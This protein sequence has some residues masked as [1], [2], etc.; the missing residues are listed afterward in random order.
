HQ[1]ARSSRCCSTSGRSDRISRCPGLLQSAA[2]KV[3]IVIRVQMRGLEIA[4]Q[5]NRCWLTSKPTSCWKRRRDVSD[6]DRRDNFLTVQAL[7]REEALMLRVVHSRLDLVARKS[8]RDV[9]AHGNDDAALYK[10]W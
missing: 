5:A 6:T 3:G 4:Q 10:G 8:I 7:V 9:R 1:D 2:R